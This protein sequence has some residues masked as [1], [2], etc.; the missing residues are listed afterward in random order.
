MGKETQFSNQIA[1]LLVKFHTG[2]KFLFP[3]RILTFCMN[4]VLQYSV[5]RKY[6]EIKKNHSGCY[7]N[8]SLCSIWDIC[9]EFEYVL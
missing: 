6:Q 3:S 9:R 5:K 7:K 4:Y 2:G 8:W 1:V